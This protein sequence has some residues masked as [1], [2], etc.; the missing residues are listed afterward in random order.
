M[1]RKTG[2][3][4]VDRKW[5]RNDSDRAAIKAGHWFDEGAAAKVCGFFKFLRHSKGRYAGKPF[6][7]EPWQVDFLSRLF[8]WK[9]PDGFR[10]FRES[11]LEI[12]KK[13]G[14]STLLS[15]ICLYGLFEEP[16][17]EVYTGAVDREQAKIV[18]GEAARM[19]R[20]SPDL[21]R[22][23]KII[24][25]RIVFSANNAKFEAMSS[26]APSK[27]GVNAS[28]CVLDELHRFKNDSLYEVMEYAGSARD[29]PLRIAITTA[30]I[31]R[32]SLCYRLHQQAVRIAEG[33][34]EDL[35]FLG[36]IYAADPEKDDIDD[37]A[38]WRKA[39]PGLGSII[40]E[41]TFAEEYR[42]AKR[43]D[44]TLNNFLRLRLNIW[45]E[46]A[47]RWLSVTRWDQLAIEPPDLD[48]Q[49]CYATLDLSSVTDLTALTLGFPDGDRVHFRT[50]YFVPEDSAELRAEVD[51]VPYPLW[52][53]ESH[54][55]L[56]PG[57]ATDHDAIINFIAGT[58]ATDDAEAVPGLADK[59]EIVCVGM[60]PWNAQHVANKLS[61]KGFRVEAFRQGYGSLSGPSKELE[62]LIL[63]GRASHEGNPVT[64]WCV[65][66]VAIESDAAGNIK[67]SKKKSTER[68][69]GV[70]AMVMSLGLIMADEG[71]L[72]PSITILG[73]SQ[74]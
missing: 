20:S 41:K 12:P 63:T 61:E 65:S 66:N 73:A 14:K 60:D 49:R 31:N 22:R 67:P 51:R 74:S 47:E 13:N 33:S 34:A 10:R 52:G 7:L 9:R 68:I 40:S 70:V 72:D 56:T 15:G 21:A 59:H 23:L 57:K 3:P 48:G 37:P 69:D 58:E 11:Y 39:N 4:G 16:G 1:A 50:Y 42:K 45:T 28:M 36:V 30:G 27:D 38:T 55:I 29:Q 35:S 46:Q 26:D 5:I 43:L 64:R 62:R 19:A 53:K 24:N 54:L 6:V 44:R 8:G 2:R 71:P 32:H 25:S 18:F 17:A